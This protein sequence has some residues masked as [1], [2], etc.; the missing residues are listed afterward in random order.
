LDDDFVQIYKIHSPTTIHYIYT[1]QS[2]T[3]ASAPLYFGSAKDLLIK[4]IGELAPSKVF[5]L[6]DENT[7][8]FCPPLDHG[9]AFKIL[10]PSG[11]SNKNLT[12]CQFI[13]EQLSDKEADREALVVNLG[14][15]VICDMGG[16]A[17]ATYKRGVRFIHVPTTLLAQV[18]AAVGGKTG[19]DLFNLKNM[20]GLFTE[21]EAVIVDRQYLNTLSDR[22]LRNGWAEVIK[23]HLLEGKE[24]PAGSIKDLVTEELVHAS[25]DFKQRIVEQDKVE[26]GV[27]KMLN[28]GHT[29][30]HALESLG[31]RMGFDLLHG[32]AV[33]A[34]MIMESHMS[35]SEG[36]SN[37]AITQITSN[38][39]AHFPKT[40]L[41]FTARQLWEFMRHDKKNKGGDVRMVKFKEPGAPVWDVYCSS[42]ELELAVEHYQKL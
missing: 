33:A 12:T 7:D 41:P 6:V 34:G 14:G 22:Q 29:V 1:M 9:P 13:W 37:D 5:Y 11:E 18:D 38:I 3:Q 27:R 26:K 39:N 10:T 19:I 40:Q 31:L 35:A 32:E 30:G 17:A 42:K 15:G 24:L 20:I 21:P 25:I 23:H 2:A 8:Q 28:F 36:L 16:F 4:V